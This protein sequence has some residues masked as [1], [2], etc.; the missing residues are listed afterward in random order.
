MF[1]RNF[2]AGR[3]APFVDAPLFHPTRIDPALLF[4]VEVASDCLLESKCY[5][6]L[7]IEELVESVLVVNVTYARGWSC[8]RP[9]RW[10]RST[11]SALIG[12]RI[13][14]PIRML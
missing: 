9:I 2:L 7:N 11:G 3:G 14:D 4:T 1:L 13:F 12:W 5:T 8:T 6:V 10:H